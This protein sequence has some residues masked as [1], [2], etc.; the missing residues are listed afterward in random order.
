MLLRPDTSHPKPTAISTNAAALRRPA[1]T[2]AAFSARLYGLGFSPYMEGQYP[3]LGSEIRE[4][5]LR[6]RMAL[7]APYTQ[8]V[9]TYGMTHGLAAAGRVAHELGLKV[10]LQAWLGPDVP[11][12]QNDL[13]TAI[14]IA[15]AK[16]KEADLLIVGSEVLFR[17][18]L[19]PD[20]LI[21][22]IR[23]VKQAVPDLAVTTADTLA[24]LEQHPTVVAEIDEVLVDI[25]PFW[26][27]VALDEAVPW[28][29]QQYQ[30]AQTLAGNKPVMIGE[31]GWPSCGEAN[32]NADASPENAARYFGDFVV[33]ARTNNVP[34]F[35]FEA[36]DEDWK[37]QHEGE[38]G[39]CWGILDR[40]GRLKPGMQ[41]GF[42]WRRQTRA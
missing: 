33:W 17:A 38:R 7:S 13:Q 5:Q 27:G 15:A 31:T 42:R 21:A 24:A 26:D 9:R 34:Y 8:W 4:Q 20:Q 19:S 40:D 3:D 12:N 35:Y 2:T 29:S 36:F 18:D 37:A 32:G 1:P 28:L 16:A 41:D 10:A 39:A 6:A 11:G 14:L 25:Y 22:Y 30:R 23:Q